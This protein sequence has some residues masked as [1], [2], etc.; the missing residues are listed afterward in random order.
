MEEMMFCVFI[1]LVAITV[2][3]FWKYHHLKHDVYDYTQSL[4]TTIN[5]MLKQEE[6]KTA[7]YE[8]DDIWG[9]IY[10]KLVRLSYFMRIKT[11][12]FQKKRIN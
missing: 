6:L 1:I 11:R 2:F 7:S 3:A 9:K 5:H 10:G 12:R 8:K 4:D